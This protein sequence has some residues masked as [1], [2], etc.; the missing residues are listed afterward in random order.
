MRNRYSG[1]LNK[2]A[3][4]RPW[5]AFLL[6]FALVFVRYCC[7]GLQYF[8]Q[9][10]DYIQHHNYAAY[11]PDHWQFILDLGLLAARPLAGILDIMLWSRFWPNMIAG[12]ALISALFAGSAVLFRQ[13]WRRY[14]GT[15]WLFIILYALFPL[16]M[17]GTYW[18]SAS[19][20]IVPSMFLAA[21]SMLMLQKWCGE[22]KKRYLAAFFFF[23]LLSFGFY[24]QT[25]VLSFTGAIIVALLELKEHRSRAL[26][27]LLSFVN[28]LIYF[29]SSA[30]FAKGG[31]YSSR[32][33]IVLPWQEGWHEEVLEPISEQMSAAFFDGG[34]YTLVRGFRR[35]AAML[36]S[37]GLWLWLLLALALCVLLFF[38][39]WKERRKSLA[40]GKAALALLVGLLM[41]AAPLS[42]FFVLANPWLS[43]RGTLP[44]FCGAA[45]ILDTLAGLVLSRLRMGKTIA[46]ALCSVC[47]LVFSIAAVSEIYDYRATTENDALV[48]SAV[49]EATN[50]GAALPQEGLCLLLG[51]EPNYVGEQNFFFHEHMHG[52]TESDWALTGALRCYS[53][54]GDFPKVKPLP[55]WTIAETLAAETYDVMYLYDPDSAT[56][57][58]AYAVPASDGNFDIFTSSDGEACARVTDKGLIRKG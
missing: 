17:E 12:V 57:R 58:Q 30:A 33:K 48:A 10:D 41:T 26:W 52:V 45:L 49:C 4:E 16:G 38:L 35:G 29:S 40:F 5:L 23:Q 24:E 27:A 39:V 28:V 43:L 53:G 8:P 34:F 21:L 44:S 36:L 6:V 51:V 32:M 56:V 20:R 14:F 18:M 50:D 55:S 46:A 25:L 3:Q 11:N 13:V 47:A 42:I 2:S 9:L 54:N 22:G 15:G 31:I 1:G 37:D 19:T 7:C